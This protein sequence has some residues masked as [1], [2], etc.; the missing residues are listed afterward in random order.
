MGEEMSVEAQLAVINTKLDTLLI[1]R[2]DHEVRLRALEQ[3]TES[4]EVRTKRDE[5]IARL[6]QFRWLLMGAA[7]AGSAGAGIG[8]TA[9][10]RAIAG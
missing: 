3:N 8:S 6:E 2:D 5:R 10:F 9:L 1:Q 4:P 7:I